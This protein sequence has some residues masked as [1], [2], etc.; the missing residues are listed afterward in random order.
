LNSIFHPPHVLPPK[1]YYSAADAFV[2]RHARA[3]GGAA[4]D[5]NAF[6]R[7]AVAKLAD[8]T[9]YVGVAPPKVRELDPAAALIAG[10]H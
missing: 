2:R 3:H 1:A 4:P 7:W 6:R 9:G 8:L 5:I 10:G